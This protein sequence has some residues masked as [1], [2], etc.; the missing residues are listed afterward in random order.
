MTRDDLQNW[1]N[2]YVEAWRANKPETIAELFSED[3]VY[4]F[5]PYDEGEQA[6][7]GRD[8]IVTAWLETPDDPTSWEANYQAFAVDD[9]RAVATGT[10]RYL[11]AG[12]KEERFYHNCFLMRFDREGR[13]TEFTEFYVRRPS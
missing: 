10:S 7:R 11:A 8:Q 6:A 3:A 2:R 13:C 12:D 9:D 5:H 1:L 4:S